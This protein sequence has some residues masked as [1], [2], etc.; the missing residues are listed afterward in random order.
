LASSDGFA[1]R[2]GEIYLDTAAEGLLPACAAEGA[3]AY[4]RDKSRGSP[5]RQAMFEEEG[6]AKAAA[7]RLLG[8]A[9]EDVA[10]LPSASDALNLVAASLDWRP[11]DQVVST[12]L[13]FPSGIL[14]FLRLKDRGVR[15][16]V[17]PSRGGTV[18]AAQICSAIGPATRVVMLSQVSYKTGTIMRELPEIAREAHRRGALLCVDATQAMGRTPVSMDGVDFLTASSYKWLLGTHGAGIACLGAGLLDRMRPAAAGWY[19]VDDLFGANRFTDFRPKAGAAQ[20]A[21]GMP[22]FPAIYALRRSLEMLEAAGIPRIE[23]ELAPLM[24][25]LRSG[26]CRLGLDVLTPA[27]ADGDSGIV[28]FAHPEHQAIGAALEKRGIVVW[29]GD[30]RV[31]ASVH[32][33][34]TVA[35]VEALLQGLEAVMAEEAIVNC[36]KA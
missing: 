13:E 23:Q 1:R 32:L 19:S 31:R 4:L 5:G 2:S 36:T 30:G 20:L 15:L 28:S 22:N 29:R 6:K 16:E 10:F 17:V 25:A 14:A 7:A 35:D 26:F 8:A 33:Y 34:N 27:G 11:G 21:A 9:A 3:E 12:D 24:A 18:S